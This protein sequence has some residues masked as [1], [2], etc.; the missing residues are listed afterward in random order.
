MFLTILRKIELAEKLWHIFFFCRAFFLAKTV[1]NSLFAGIFQY[2]LVLKCC[3]PAGYLG[4]IKSF[5]GGKILAHEAD[6]KLICVIILCEVVDDL[7][8]FLYV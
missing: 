5:V 3:E 2:F 1:D 7:F 6:V 4:K 8:A